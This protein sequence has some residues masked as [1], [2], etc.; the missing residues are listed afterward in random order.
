MVNSLED[1]IYVAWSMK[2]R[3]WRM[4]MEYGYALCNMESVSFADC[5]SAINKQN[6]VSQTRLLT[7]VFQ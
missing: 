3:A 2:H 7:G 1:D 4:G 5:Q 6:V